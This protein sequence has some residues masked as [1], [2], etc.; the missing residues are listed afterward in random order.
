MKPIDKLAALG[1][2]YKEALDPVERFQV[3]KQ[4]QE[5]KRRKIE[6]EEEQREQRRIQSVRN[7]PKLRRERSRSQAQVLSKRV[8]KYGTKEKFNDEWGM[9]MILPLTKK[10]LATSKDDIDDKTLQQ[11]EDLAPRLKE[12]I[13]IILENQSD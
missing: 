1:I 4:L 3:R 5:E 12:V 13:A 8:A 10:L 6:R 11:L 7:A 9:R 2:S